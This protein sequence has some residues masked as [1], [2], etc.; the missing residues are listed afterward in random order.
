MTPELKLKTAAEEI[1]EILRKYDIAASIALHTP[2]HGEYLNHIL[3][4]YSCAY[5]YNDETVRIYSKLK[6]YKSKEEQVQKQR[7]TANM[8]KMLADLTAL[9]FAQVSELSEIMDKAT[10]AI[11]F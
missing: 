5:Q 2:N 10:D 8:L 6:D 9:N 11:H 3:T 1:K 7:D 4:S